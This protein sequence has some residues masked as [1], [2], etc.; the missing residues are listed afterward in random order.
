MGKIN[1]FKNKSESNKMSKCTSKYSG[2]S[3]VRNSTTL[4]GLST[5]ANSKSM[6]MNDRGSKDKE[7][8]NATEELL[9][10]FYDPQKEMG[11]YREKKEEEYRC[12]LEESEER[13]QFLRLYEESKKKLSPEER[14]DFESQH[15]DL[16]HL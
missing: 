11:K 2:V 9:L 16:I 8:Q 3:K 12:L 1:E 15:Y 5:L 7:N 13:R 6:I 4:L 10:Y 14:I